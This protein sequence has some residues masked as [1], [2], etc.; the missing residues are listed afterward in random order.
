[1]NRGRKVK[2][3]ISVILIALVSGFFI[4]DSVM[5]KVLGK[6]PV[7]CIM[8]AQYSDGVSAAYY[9]AGYKIKRDYN[10]TDGSESYSITLW[11]LPFSVS[12]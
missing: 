10:V 11:L 4:T 2:R 12:L 7:F 8:A 3:V 1:M 5:T 9:G 6:P